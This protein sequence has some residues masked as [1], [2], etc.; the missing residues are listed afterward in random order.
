MVKELAQRITKLFQKK[1]GLSIKGLGIQKELHDF[2]A[3]LEDCEVLRGKRKSNND[4]K[5]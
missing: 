1:M 5:F 4:F 2:Y 3:S